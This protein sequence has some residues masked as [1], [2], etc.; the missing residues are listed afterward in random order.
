MD[1]SFRR[2]ITD[3]N[4]QQVR[5]TNHYRRK[6][7]ALFPRKV[8]QQTFLTLLVY[9]NEGFE[10]GQTQVLKIAFQKQFEIIF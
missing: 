1:G 3:S 7:E 10:G 6:S 2:I 8:Q 9:L 4:G 5:R